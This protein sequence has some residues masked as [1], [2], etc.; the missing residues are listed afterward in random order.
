MA[1]PYAGRRGRAGTLLRDLGW[2]LKTLADE[3][4]AGPK[5]LTTPSAHPARTVASDD[6]RPRPW[7]RRLTP[8][9]P[10]AVLVTVFLGTLARGTRPVDFDALY[11][12]I[13]AGKVIGTAD[14]PPGFIEARGALSA[15]IYV[16][17][18]LL[19]ELLGAGGALVA[20][21]LQNSLL[22]ALVAAFLL[23]RLAGRPHDPWT[24]WGGAALVLVL[25]SP[26]APYALVDLYPAVALL[27]AMLLLRSR[28][29]VALGSAGFLLAFAVGVRPSFLVPVLLLVVVVGLHRL[30]VLLPVGGGA[31]LGLL[32]QSLVN[33]Y[34]HGTPLPWPVDSAGLVRLQASYASYVVRYDT[35]PAAPQPQLFHCSPA[36][37]ELVPDPPPDGLFELARHLLATLPDSLLFALEKVG[38]AF[39]WGWSTPYA[40]IG[41]PAV[42]ALGVVV[43]LVS[44]IGVVSVV[45]PVLGRVRGP[46]AERS[47]AWGWAVIAGGSALTLVSSTP[48][49]RFA[50]PVVLVGVVGCTAAIAQRHRLGDAS[51]GRV[52]W[53][54]PGAVL[55]ALLLGA[56]AAGMTHPAPPGDVTPATCSATVADALPTPAAP[57]GTLDRRP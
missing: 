45:R 5:P 24:L 7:S 4:Q 50:L 30:R 21:L 40:A 46:A 2:E 29:P 23:P 20:V 6:P 34:V 10:W 52:P 13:A 48:E 56:G 38:A 42:T 11:Y 27:L 25:V 8:L 43:A 3:G 17:A 44:G 35:V 55:A 37:A 28:H 26:F 19:T 14:T 18:A 12:W 33:L 1:Q 49:A 22:V 54:L 41:E 9:H 31:A 57:A 15:L 32:P 51:W 36:M 39:L 16:P 47:E 53:W